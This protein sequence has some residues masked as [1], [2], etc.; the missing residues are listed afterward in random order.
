MYVKV[1]LKLKSGELTT[2]RVELPKDIRDYHEDT[3]DDAV[4]DVLTEK[5]VDYKWY[6]VENN[7]VLTTKPYV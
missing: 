7:K 4:S 3:V 5:G 6:R 1:R 2:I